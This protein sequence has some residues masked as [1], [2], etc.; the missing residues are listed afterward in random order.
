[1]QISYIRDKGC[2][3]TDLIIEAINNGQISASN[4]SFKRLREVAGRDLDCWGALGRGRS[5][6]TSVDQLDQYLYSYG[7][8]TQDQ[9]TRFLPS[10]SL[11]S[12]SFCLIDYGCGQGLGSAIVFDHLGF[13]LMSQVRNLVLIEP[14]QIALTRAKA[15]VEC[16]CPGSSILSVNKKLDDVLEAD[17]QSCQ[18]LHSIHIFS[19]VLDIDG[20]DSGTLFTKM[21]STKG[22]H[23]VLAVSH[24][25]NFEGGSDRLHDLEEQ[26]KD[27]KHRA[28][29]SLESSTITRFNT[30]DGKPK[31]SWQL[32]LEVLD[33]IV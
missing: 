19:N 2:G 31:I 9:W 6:L 13:K 12:G 15:I 16:Y 14:S 3:M 4:I 32:H 18:G 24:D 17:I 30:S 10:V 28:W 29:F 5:I 25:R 33:G 21:F 22:R 20:F 1:M 11:P 8:M 23:T 7:L 26:I 27:E